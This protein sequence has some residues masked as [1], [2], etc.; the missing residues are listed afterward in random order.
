[1]SDIGYIRARVDAIYKE[2]TD[3]KIK[4]AGHDITSSQFQKDIDAL[5]D[6]P[7]KT[8][9]VGRPKSFQWVP[10]VELVTATPAVIRVL[11]ASMAL[12]LALLGFHRG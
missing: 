2:V 4:C 6:R 11:V 7:R 5:K 10:F 9:E 3:I 8:V 12:L 1:M